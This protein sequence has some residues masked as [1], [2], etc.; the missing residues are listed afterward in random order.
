MRVYVTCL[1][2]AAL[3]SAAAVLLIIASYLLF[4]QKDEPI[5]T[6]SDPS[7]AYA[8]TVKILYSVSSKLNNGINA[9]EPVNKM[10]SMASK[11]MSAVARSTGMIES[12]LK[13]LGYFKKAV[14]IVN[15]P[16]E[17]VNK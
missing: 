6:F 10:E 14:N 9:L 13:P 16:L 4:I 17:K 15:S 7:L 3:S 1:W 5:D 11:S 2:R 12:N 8:E